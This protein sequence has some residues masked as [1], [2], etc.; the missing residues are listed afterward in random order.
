VNDKI[1]IAPEPTTEA[2]QPLPS[3]PD[4]TPNNLKLRREVL[5]AFCRSGEAS[6]LSAEILGKLLR[7]TSRAIYRWR[8]Q[9]TI[10]LP[11]FRMAERIID[12]LNSIIRLRKG[13]EELIE[14]RKSSSFKDIDGIVRRAFFNARL[15]GIFENGTLSQDDKIFRLTVSSLRALAVLDPLDFEIYDAGGYHD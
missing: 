2:T 6:A 11:S 13:W 8:E 5:A 15:L 14:T 3:E 10:F 7:C 12:F 4:E 1:E 9:N